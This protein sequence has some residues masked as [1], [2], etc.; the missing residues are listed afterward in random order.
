MKYKINTK[1][2][3][4]NIFFMIFSICFIIITFNII[5]TNTEY[6]YKSFNLLPLTILLVLVALLS[7][8]FVLSECE[9]FINTYYKRILIVFLAVTGVIQLIIGYSLQFEPVFD[10]G[11]I[12]N[13]AIEWVKTGTFAEIYDYMY[14]FPNNLGGMMFLFVFFKISNMFGCENFFI[15]GMVVNTLMCLATIACVSLICK[16]ILSPKSGLIALV[17]FTLSLPFYFISAAFYT[18][19]L[20]LLFAPL[21]YLLYLYFK[22]AK[23]LKSQIF[24]SIAIGLIT[25]IGTLIKFPVIIMYIAV[26]IDMLFNMP[27]KKTALVL[28]NGI[29]VIL[30]VNLCFNGYIYSSHLDSKIAKKQNTPYKHWIMM[31]LS[32]PIGAYNND[33]YIFTRSF[34][35][36]KEQNNALNNEIKERIKSRGFLG[37]INFYNKKMLFSLGDGTYALSD[38]FDDNPK[39]NSILHDYIL[40]N[41]PHYETY[42]ILSISVLIS[43]YILMISYSQYV[44]FQRKKLQNIAPYISIFGMLLFLAIWESNGRYFTCFIPIV[45]VCSVLSIDMLYKILFKKRN[46]LYNINDFFF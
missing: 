35:D 28:V 21:I 27:I 40:Y 29:V 24:Y 11:A 3:L 42:S 13:G 19:S 22:E 7:F 5:F 8:Y 34:N 23:T 33:D 9:N 44:C 12:Y 30:I 17:F 37:M 43:F 1:N 20:S 32:S 14:Y 36:A 46:N 31:G 16:K 15:V 18:D 26:I 38:F 39:N 6:P 4:L 25:A 45:F 10:M 41:G 2:I